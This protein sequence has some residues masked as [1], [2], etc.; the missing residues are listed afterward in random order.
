[1]NWT[2]ARFETLARRSQSLHGNRNVLP[3]AIAVG[4]MES[5]PVRA[6]E[7]VERLRG[8][9]APN[10]VREA[11]GRLVAAGVLAELPYG[12]RPFPRMFERL[13]SAYWMLVR[14]LAAEANGEGRA[15]SRE[16]EAPT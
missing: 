4:E 14:E 3:V 11:L 13:P 5:M 1:L 2:I 6:S 8:N 7:V 12:G 9:V 10:R 16:A 15:G